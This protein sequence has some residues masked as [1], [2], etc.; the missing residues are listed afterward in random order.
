MVPDVA[1]CADPD[2]GYE[3][4]LNGAV[5]VVG[6]TS[7]VAPLY[8]GLVAAVWGKKPGWITPEF[9]TNA[10]WFNDITLGDNGTY[11]ARVGPDPVTGMGSPK[12]DK[13]KT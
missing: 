3:V 8:A 7:A 4:V 1:A 2:T 11:A 10:E 9:Y 12:A 13:F 6:G 5:E